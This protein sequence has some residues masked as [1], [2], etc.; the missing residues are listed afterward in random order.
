[1]VSSNRSCLW[2]N[3]QTVQHA[4]LMLKRK[5]QEL[6]GQALLHFSFS[7][8]KIESKLYIQ[9]IVQYL[10]KTHT[11]GKATLAWSEK[12]PKLLPSAENKLVWIVRNNPESTNAQPL[13][14]SSWNT[15]DY[16]QSE[17]IFAWMSKKEASD[18][19]LISSSLIKVSS[20]SQGQIKVFW[21][22]CLTI[23][24]FGGANVR[25]LTPNT[26]YQLLS[27]VAVAPYHGTVLLELVEWTSWME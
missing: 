18:P 12:R 17:T 23:C 14:E 9:T 1:M 20:W 10:S 2:Q 6:E 8:M 22:R 24:V 4:F 5:P 13:P 26:L 21:R 7:D 11:R 27:M 15:N 16:T 25:Y 3:E 19:K